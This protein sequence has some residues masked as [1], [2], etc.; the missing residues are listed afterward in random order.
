MSTEQK[1][2]KVVQIV[3]NDFIQIENLKDF[4]YIIRS[5]FLSIQ[6]NKESAKLIYT[7]LQEWLK[8]EDNEE[9]NIKMLRNK[10]NINSTKQFPLGA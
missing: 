10:A 6:V 1:E 5:G 8:K 9:I 7:T 3:G 4:A 2:Q